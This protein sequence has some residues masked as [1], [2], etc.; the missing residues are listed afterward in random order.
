MAVSSTVQCLAATP[1]HPKLANLDIRFPISH[2]EILAKFAAFLKSS[3]VQVGPRNKRICIIE[4]IVSTP[5]VLMPWQEMVQMCKDEGIWTL[6][7]AA[8]SIGHELDINLSTTQ[9]DFWVSVSS[10]GLL[11]I[12]TIIYLPGPPIELSQM[13]IREEALCGSIRAV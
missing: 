9:P 6:V 4:S 10:F 1:P 13:V 5:G 2:D 11:S 8:H 12:S 3:Q 7:D